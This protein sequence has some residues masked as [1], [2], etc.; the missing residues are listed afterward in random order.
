MKKLLLLSLLI[1]I[2]F[3]GYSQYPIKTIFKGDSV[4][5]LTI[6]QSESINKSIEKNSRLVKEGNKKIQE[7]EEKI[8]E[9]EEI[10]RDQSQHI[11]S[12][13]SYLLDYEREELGVYDSL[14]KWALN[15]SLIYTQYPNDSTLYIMDLSRY[16]LTTDDFGIIMVRMSDK[17]YKKY[18][19][20]ISKYGLSEEAFWQFRNDMRIKQ[21]KDAEITERRVWKYKR[22][23]NKEIK[24]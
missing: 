16:Y 23:W 1:V 5:I 18:Q 14:W 7:Y 4:I 17:E 13:K 19:A 2:S 3:T 12:L 15:P 20:F 21:V 6:Q 10:N 22:H 24:K 9:L 11:D 8:K